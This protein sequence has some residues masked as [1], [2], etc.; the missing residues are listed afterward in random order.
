MAAR[1]L[2]KVQ[3]CLLSTLPVPSLVSLFF[4]PSNIQSF[5]LPH[6]WFLLFLMLRVPLLQ[7]FVWAG[8]SSVRSQLMCFFFKEPSITI[9]IIFFFTSNFLTS[10]YLYNYLLIVHLFLLHDMFHEGRNYLYIVL[11]YFSRAQSGVW[12]RGTLFYLQ[13]K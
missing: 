11:G 1:R 9:S 5:F 6:A 10:P 12:H 8:S 2:Y 3:P 13:N 4:N 7:V